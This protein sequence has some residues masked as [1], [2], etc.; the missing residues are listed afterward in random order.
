MEALGEKKEALRDFRAVVGLNASIADAVTGVRRLETELGE[1]PTVARR[2]AGQNTGRV[3]ADVTAEDAK[4][5][6][7]AGQQ[8]RDV[9]VQKA[10]AKEQDGM[11]KREKRQLELTIAQM[12]SMPAGVET[13]RP[14][15]KMFMRTPRDELTKTM[16]EKL[17]KAE[18]KI[19]VCASTLEY[20]E[21][22]EKE[23]AAEYKRVAEYI[24]RKQAAA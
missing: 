11:A 5:L 6:D 22:Q 21:R 15:G 10:K 7:E 16:S 9:A 24:M 20:I 19:K 23:A 14:I 3:T 1:R 13:F 18:H 17:S 4:Q 8:V 12:S 2:E